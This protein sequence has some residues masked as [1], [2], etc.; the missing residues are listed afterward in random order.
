MGCF[1]PL[2]NSKPSTIPRNVSNLVISEPICKICRTA[3]RFRVCF[4]QKYKMGFGSITNTLVLEEETI[5]GSSH[6][7]LA[8]KGGP[9]YSCYYVGQTFDLFLLLF[10]KFHFFN[11]FLMM[12]LALVLTHFANTVYQSST[13]LHKSVNMDIPGMAAKCFKLV[14]QFWRLVY[15]KEARSNRLKAFHSTQWRNE[16]QTFH[17]CRAEKLW[18]FKTWWGKLVFPKSQVIFWHQNW[19][20]M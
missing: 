18:T 2:L 12:A 6:I 7:S 3:F 13:T 16:H 10:D 19:S 8:K 5:Q 14:M 1:L 9:R 11:G 17:F 15:P 4:G 20:I